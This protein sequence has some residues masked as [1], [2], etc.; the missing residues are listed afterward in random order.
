MFLQQVDSGERL[1][2]G[3][4]GCSIFFL[5]VISEV[6]STHVEI[7]FEETV[8][9]VRLGREEEGGFSYFER[10]ENDYD[11]YVI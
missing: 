1:K 7:F 9:R 5:N 3:G 6:R 11:G 10:K 2:R 8:F 4:G